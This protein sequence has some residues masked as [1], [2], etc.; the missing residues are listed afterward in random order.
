MGKTQLDFSEQDREM[1]RRAAELLREEG[2]DH[3]DFTVF[4]IALVAEN[5][6]KSEKRAIMARF[7]LNRWYDA[8]R[9]KPK[10]L[11]DAAL[12]PDEVVRIQ[13]KATAKEKAAH[14]GLRMAKKRLERTLS[15]AKG[16]VQLREQEHAERLRRMQEASAPEEGERS[17]PIL[18]QSLLVS[19]Q[20]HIAHIESAIASVEAAMRCMEMPVPHP[21]APQDTVLFPCLWGVPSN[22]R[23]KSLRQQASV[24]RDA[25]WTAAEVGYVMLAGSKKEPRRRLSRRTK[26]RIRYEK[27]GGQK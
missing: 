14:D 6:R 27:Q 25:G 20:G 12:V 1:G 3:H 9:Q 16:A 15:T 10:S 8:E 22:E 18:P 26:E 11:D 21:R 4:I 5:A 2:S 17:E 13:V 19:P 23:R 24:L 7:G